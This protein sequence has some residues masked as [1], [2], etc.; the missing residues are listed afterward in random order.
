MDECMEIVHRLLSGDPMSYDGQFFQL[1]AARIVPAAVP[2]VPIVVGGRSDAAVRR[3]G[4]LG[5]GW[6]GI[7]VSS[8]RYGEVISTVERHAEEAERDDVEFTNALNVWCGVGAD[9]DD[10]RQHVAPAMERFYQL[11]F[12]RFAKWSPCGT[13][14]VV[15][16]FLAPYVE[17]GC[18][19]FNLILQAESPTA[20]LDAA[21]TIRERLIAAC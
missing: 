11:P 17:S 7:W 8:R 4:R 12:D 3:A 10:A 14:T 13:A 18:S 15:A 20:G 2:P 1:D 6:F 9:A 5:D 16:D 21:A 19:V